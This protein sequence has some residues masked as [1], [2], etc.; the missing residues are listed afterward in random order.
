MCTKGRRDRSGV[1]GAM[2]CS[3]RLGVPFA[4]AEGGGGRAP[5]NVEQV[6]PVVLPL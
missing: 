4:Q 6:Y 5:S 1:S 3:T 2:G